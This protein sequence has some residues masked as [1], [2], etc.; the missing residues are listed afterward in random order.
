MKNILDAVKNLVTRNN[1]D[2]KIFGVADNRINS[3]GYGLE[4]YVKNLF[5]DTF[6][7]TENERL[8]NWSK[9]FS[10]IGNDNNPPDIM[11]RNGDAVE[12][13][14]IQS[15]DSA[16]ALNSSYPKHILKVSDSMISNACRSAE[17]WSEKDLIYAVGVVQNNKLKHLC[18]IY[19]RNY[20]A[21][22]E[23][24]N[25]IRGMWH[26]ENPW[27]VFE[28]IYQRNFQAKFDFMCIIDDEK[29]LTLENRDEFMEFQKNYPAL[30]ISDVKI[31]NPDNPA[32]LK[33][34]KLIAYEID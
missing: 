21:S 4:N 14:K 2:L 8:I 17:N 9:I 22:E 16:L 20:C 5:A 34:A 31:K 25:K 11:L 19:G 6:D 23:C 33:D 18:M 12:V 3:V 1:I 29:W 24:Y 15:K 27:K 13:K 30:K 7:C 10:Y 26:I 28:Y 32:Q